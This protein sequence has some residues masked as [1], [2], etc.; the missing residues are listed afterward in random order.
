MELGRDV[1][2]WTMWLFDL[3]ITPWTRP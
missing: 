1:S 3:H 2:A